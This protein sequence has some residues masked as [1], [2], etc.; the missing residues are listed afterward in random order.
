MNALLPRFLKSAYRKDPIS[1]FVMTVGAV[2]AV[3]GGVGERWT[4]MSFGIMMILLAIAIRWLQIQRSQDNLTEEVPRRYLPP[5]PSDAPL[6][7]LKT[8]ERDW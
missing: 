6:P 2:D 7:M 4:L 5:S 3:I 1:S 8:K